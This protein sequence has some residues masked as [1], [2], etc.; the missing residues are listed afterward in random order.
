M[1]NAVLAG[2]IAA[3]T[4]GCAALAPAHD[5]APFGGDAP[6]EGEP[7][8]AGQLCGNAGADVELHLRLVQQMLDK[9]LFHAALA[10]L[11]ALGERRRELPEARYLRAES[12]RRVNKGAEAADLYR[13]LLSGCLQGL[14]Q[15]G[16]GLLAA[17]EGRLADAVEH[18]RLAA[19]Q[20]PT[21]PR[22]RNDL[23]YALLL[24]GTLDEA[25]P[26]FATAL[27]L[28]GDR[29]RIAGNMVLLL[30]VAGDEEGAR[31]LAGRMGIDALELAS[32]RRQAQELRRAPEEGPAHG[33]SKP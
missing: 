1:K 15:R 24:L 26:Q 23:G 21:D 22:V 3:S 29:Q 33:P 31:E 25:R 5:P 20:L 7:G 32:I 9:G 19:E 12:L 13:G 8:G 11:D 10:H 18:L 14:A 27:E 28:G 16:L 6:R 4:A 17:Q 30:L 2:L